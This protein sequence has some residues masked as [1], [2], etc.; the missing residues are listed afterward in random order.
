VRRV[1][2]LGHSPQ[3]EIGVLGCDIDPDALQWLAFPEAFREQWALIGW[4]WIKSDHP[5]RAGR[6]DLANTVDCCSSGHATA[7]NQIGIM[8]HRF[9]LLPQHQA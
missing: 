9:L 2:R 4:M 1:K 8:R 5:N 3:V 7:D 6:V